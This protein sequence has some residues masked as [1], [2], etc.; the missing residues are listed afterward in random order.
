[1]DNQ[2]F[3]L[4]SNTVEL[5]VDLIGSLNNDVT[6]ILQRWVHGDADYQ[7][8]SDGIKVR[9]WVNE[10]HMLVGHLQDLPTIPDHVDDDDA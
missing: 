1:M 2:E 8:S 4:S 10:L 9:K 5:I 7:K 6:E 3:K